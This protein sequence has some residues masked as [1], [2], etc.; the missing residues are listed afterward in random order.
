MKKQTTNRDDLIVARRKHGAARQVRAVHTRD[1]NDRVNLLKPQKQLG[2]RV[3]PSTPAERLSAGEGLPCRA[4]DAESKRMFAS[5][6]L[7]TALEDA[8]ANLPAAVEELV[9][10]RVTA[11]CNELD[12]TVAE[13]ADCNLG[14]LTRYDARLRFIIHIYGS[15]ALLIA[16]IGLI[17]LILTH[18]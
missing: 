8:I 6:E 16:T 14:F 4:L 9:N 2:R 13:V 3:R 5:E 15:A 18:R 1:V 11:Q 10:D 7:A 12:S 17:L